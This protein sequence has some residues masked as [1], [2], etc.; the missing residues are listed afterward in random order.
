M[1]AI[2]LSPTGTLREHMRDTRNCRAYHERERSE[3][4]NDVHARELQSRDVWKLQRPEMCTSGDGSEHHLPANEDH[5]PNPP[6]SLL[7]ERFGLGVIALALVNV[8]GGGSV[9]LDNRCHD[10]RATGSKVSVCL[11]NFLCT[12]PTLLAQHNHSQIPALGC[13]E[14]ALL[15]LLTMKIVSRCFFDGV[16][17]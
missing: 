9:T 2:A 14:V 11:L 4:R 3:R 12:A 7:P 1:H 16:T 13:Y 15:D 10:L 6:F 8:L 5:H 17:F